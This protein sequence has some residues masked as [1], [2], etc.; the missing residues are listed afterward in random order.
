MTLVIGHRAMMHGLGGEVDLLVLDGL[1]KHYR[2]VVALDG[3]GLSVA[4]GRMVGFL[5]PNGAGKTSAMRAVFGLLRLDAGTV[6]WNGR[7]VSNEDRR[8]FGYIPEARGLYPRMKVRNQIVYLGRLH[9]LDKNTAADAAA[10][11]IERVGLED[12]AGSRL[13]EL[14]HGN[15]QRAQLVAALVHDPELLVL[16]EPF[17]GL[18]P[19]GVEEMARILRHRADAGAAVLF[20]SHQLDLVE[21]LCDDVAIINRGRVVV[22]GDVRTLKDRSS[23]RRLEVDMDSTPPG[24]PTV[25]AKRRCWRRAEP[26]IPCWSPPAPMSTICSH[27]CAGGE[28]SGSSRTVRPHCRTCS[29]R[30]CGHERLPGHRPRYAA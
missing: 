20:S 21:G 16:D 10:R 14:S 24:S 6:T 1:K 17:S 28:G 22:A 30:R 5:G 25:W 2:E 7:P 23:Y 4:P 26:G 15:Q 3:C 12:R 27:R 11:W 8:R 29:R 13:E 18:D 9:G 19:L